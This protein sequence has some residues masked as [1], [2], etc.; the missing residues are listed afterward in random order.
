MT[1]TSLPISSK[2]SI[3]VSLDSLASATYV[4]ATAI[5]LTSI[6]PIDCLIETVVVTTASAPSGNKQVE[7]YI[8]YSLDGTNY[9]S[10]PESGTTT[11]D[12]PV[13]Y[14]IGAIPTNGASTTYRRTLSVRE[15]LGFCPPYIKVIY[16]NDLGTALSTGCSAAYAT[17]VANNA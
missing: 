2:S 10:G 15:A 16:K 17:A 8:K 6:D 9:T 1:T 5:D 13:L 3:T 11:T 4:A 12:E 14:R 7:V